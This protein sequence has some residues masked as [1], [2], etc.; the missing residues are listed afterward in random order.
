MDEKNIA[1]L[2]FVSKAADYLKDKLNDDAEEIKEIG[3][4]DLD[5]IK[6][7]L[8][9]KLDNSFSS[10]KNDADDL[11]NAGQ[12][13]FESFISKKP[14]M[15]DEF[16]DIFNVDFKKEND[17]KD[18][19]IINHLMSILKEPVKQD[20]EDEYVEMISKAASL[21]VEEEKQEPVEI[22][23]NDD[24]D[25]EIDDIFSEIM[26]HEENNNEDENIEEE[27]IDDLFNNE[28]VKEEVEDKKEDSKIT[29]GEL[30]TILEDALG[31]V[32]KEINRSNEEILEKFK[33][34]EDKINS[35]NN[36]LE[37][38]EE[39]ASF[40][41]VET[42]D[43]EPIPLSESLRRLKGDE[44]YRGVYTYNSVLRKDYKEEKEDY[45]RNDLVSDYFKKLKNAFVDDKT[46]DEIAQL[47]DEKVSDDN[48]EET[49]EDNT[50]EETK[51]D[52]MVDAA[53]EAIAELD[54]DEVL[55]IDNLVKDVEKV[56][57][58]VPAF[59]DHTNYVEM[60]STE[61]YVIEEP[62]KEEYASEIEENEIPIIEENVETSIKN[63]E[64]DNVETNVEL[65][66]EI[67][68]ILSHTDVKEEEVEPSVEENSVDVD[69]ILDLE[70]LSSLLENLKVEEKA[71]ESSL[72]GNKENDVPTEETIN[73]T[74]EIHKDISKEIKPAVEEIQE[75]LEE[76]TEPEIINILDENYEDIA[77]KLQ[78]VAIELNGENEPIVEEEPIIDETEPIVEEPQ[79]VVE[80]EPVVEETVEPQII[81]IF[82]ENYED[83]ASKLKNIVIELNGEVEP[84]KEEIK[85][86][87]ENEPVESIIQDIPRFDE[88]FDQ[89]ALDEESDAKE[90]LDELSLQEENQ[91]ER[92][93]IDE[94]YIEDYNNR[95]L[96]Q[97]YI[98]N[99]GLD[100]L[101]ESEELEE[102]SVEDETSNIVLEE[103]ENVE[104]TKD[105]IDELLDD[106]DDDLASKLIKEREAEE[107]KNEVYESIKTLYPYLTNG[108]IKGVYELK[109]SLARDYKDEEEIIILHRLV[110]RN[111]DGLRR[112]AEIMMSHDYMVNVDE[113]QM[114]VDAFKEHINCDGKILTDIFEV[115]NQAR[116]LTG[117][118]EGYRIIEKDGD[119]QFE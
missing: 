30:K 25:Q 12:E 18:E 111:V 24:K 77:S 54:V 70:T 31:N 100:A 102:E 73:E 41:D 92:T 71:N 3:K 58:K 113:K 110:F 5:M 108:F 4:V 115:A 47:E 97:I 83:I 9:S 72:E 88:L 99:P 51:T 76:H 45:D 84:V 90:S 42:K 35:S 59:V 66:D 91:E 86:E 23:K 43:Y 55:S 44:E 94:A 60:E 57:N 16:A 11:I 75:T 37:V 119:N 96:D 53:Y 33:N 15:I 29:P 93:F 8:S 40:E 104:E 10:T 67:D 78:D 64:T 6:S 39:P 28:E 112:F 116:L 34:V 52:E 13:A 89:L 26:A 20:E 74:E 7:E 87:V 61:E 48:N 49:I 56:A 101:Q 82:E 27:T 65:E 105:E 118:Y 46:N 21:P 79:E 38:E 2:G 63:V 69:D 95:T 109:E 85:Q 1:L 22:Y 107:A 117:E 114:I 62:N 106:V 14:K 103:Q 17:E 80:D 68:E 36:P 32:Y 50:Q 98:A 81:N 19:K